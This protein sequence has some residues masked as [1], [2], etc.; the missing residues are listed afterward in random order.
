MEVVAVAAV[1]RKHYRYLYLGVET[2]GGFA[3]VADVE[4][5]LDGFL[6]VVAVAVAVAVAGTDVAESI[7]LVGSAAAHGDRKTPGLFD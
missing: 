1:H 2:V 5:L 6:V 7:D 4:P 3:V